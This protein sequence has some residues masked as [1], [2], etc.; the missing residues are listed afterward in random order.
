[1]S[2]IDECW[3]IEQWG[4]DDESVAAEAM[5]RS[6]LLFAGCFFELI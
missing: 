3:Q 4:P 5:R 2:R 1:L 6:D